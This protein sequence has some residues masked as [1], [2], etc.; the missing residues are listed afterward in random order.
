MLTEVVNGVSE[1]GLDRCPFDPRACAAP[2]ASAAADSMP[3]QF[4]MGREL[5]RR[6]G[7]PLGNDHTMVDAE[8][9]LSRRP[10]PA[11]RTRRPSAN[12]HL[13]LAATSKLQRI[14]TCLTTP[15][16]APETI[17]RLRAHGSAG[18][19]GAVHRR[20]LTRTPPCLQPIA[21]PRRCGR[22]IPR[23]WRGCTGCR[24]ERTTRQSP[25]SGNGHS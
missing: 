15:K 14:L 8:N 16:M 1:R 20:R 17:G 22:P 21:R 12:R 2:A 23:R 4:A 7:H 18:R 13:S 25:A 19:S 6:K 11:G 10:G 24:L 5:R 9:A 3:P